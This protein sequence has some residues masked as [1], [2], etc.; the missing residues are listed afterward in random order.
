MARI[1]VH[2]LSEQIR[3]YHNFFEI[4]GH[5][6]L[7]TRMISRIRETLGVEMQLKTIF[8]APR[9]TCLRMNSRN[10]PGSRWPCQRRY[11]AIGM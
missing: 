6:L 11:S 9:S 5:S 10:V 4:G 3:P 1:G 2:F 8:D 7:A